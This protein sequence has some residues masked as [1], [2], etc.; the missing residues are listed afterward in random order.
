MEYPVFSGVWTCDNGMSE[1]YS[2]F[3][4]DMRQQTW[5]A[6]RPAAKPDLDQRIATGFNRNHRGNAENDTDSDEYQVE[7]AV[8]PE[9]RRDRRPG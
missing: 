1:N 8:L 9:V 4:G 5:L 6:G 2:L 3:T 7:Y